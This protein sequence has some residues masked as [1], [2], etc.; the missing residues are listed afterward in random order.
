MK[1]AAALYAAG[2]DSIAKLRLD[3]YK[4]TL[5]PK[6]VTSLKYLEHIQSPTPREHAE[7]IAVCYLSLCAEI[8]NS[9]R[10]D[11]AG[12]LQRFSACGQIRSGHRRSIVRQIINEQIIPAETS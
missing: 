5:S 7:M 2:C 10:L 9:R 6:V 8:E 11:F 3:E 12:L 1:S 4:S